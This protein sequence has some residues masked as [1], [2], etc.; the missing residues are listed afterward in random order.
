MN[1]V[2]KVNKPMKE[3]QAMAKFFKHVGEHNGK[4]VVIV[5]KSIPGEP[6]MC[7]VIYT[8]IIPSKFHDDI[9]RVLESSE[10]QAEREFGLILN[11]RVGTDGINLLQAIA[12][13]GYLKKAPTNQ[14]IVKPNAS[15][16][17]RLDELNN[18]LR[19]AGEG[20]EAIAKLEK[21]ERE[22]GLKDNRKL[23]PAGNNPIKAPEPVVDNLLDDSKLAQNY[24]AQS[25]RMR[26]EAASLLAEAEKLEAE[27]NK[28]DPKT[29]TKG[30]KR[31]KA[32][33]VTA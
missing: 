28:L 3:K 33:K 18:L 16:A 31:G 1:P 15:S 22:S 25:T 7:A 11:R 2:L 9:M 4:K 6:H 32:A 12:Q 20:E 14:V 29:K 8:S 5:E 13:E 26:A 21:L 24:I 10:G 17:I 23:N 30:S 27:A 19:M